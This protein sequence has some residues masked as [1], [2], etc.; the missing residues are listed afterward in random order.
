[1]KTALQNNEQVDDLTGFKLHS[2]RLPTHLNFA[3]YIFQQTRSGLKQKPLR[4]F[5]RG[6][7]KLFSKRIK[8]FLYYCLRGLGFKNNV[9]NA[10]KD[11][12]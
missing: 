1:M 2:G 6:F 7:G 9:C 11:N 5:F 4:C 8:V 10:A 12:I 3:I